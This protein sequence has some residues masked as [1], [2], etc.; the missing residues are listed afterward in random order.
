MGASRDPGYAS[1]M[2]GA[3]SFTVLTVV[4]LGLSLDACSTPAAVAD[5]SG[6]AAVADVAADI[7]PGVDAS[8]PDASPPDS[9]TVDAGVDGGFV[10]GALGG[11]Y[12]GGVKAC[13]SAG[14]CAMIA[15]GCYCGA[16]PV[17][18]ISKAHLAAAEACEA[19]A[20]RSCALGC[21]NAPGRVAED[22]RNDLEGGTLAVAC[23]LGECHTLL[24]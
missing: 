20:R 7:A 16:Q 1:G 13:A 22:G 4:T 3:L 5:A 17:I 15:R 14:D 11:T 24:P 19:A 6:D 18:G 21:P 12:A 23:E 10:C 2:R 8:V 9:A